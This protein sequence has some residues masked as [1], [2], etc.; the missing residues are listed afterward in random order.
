MKAREWF[1]YIVRCG[2]DSLYTGVAKDIAARLEAHNSGRGAAYTR[3]HLPVKLV[4]KEK[5]LTRSA[6]L[7]REARIK[8]LERAEKLH[9]IKEAGRARTRRPRSGHNKP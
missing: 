4:Y 6:A 3:A 2:D 8:A 7:T 1:V 9:L 5:G